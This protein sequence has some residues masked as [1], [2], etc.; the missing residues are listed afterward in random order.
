MSGYTPDGEPYVRT[1]DES[2]DG[3]YLEHN[4]IS[5]NPKT[6]ATERIHW[7]LDLTTP[8]AKPEIITDEE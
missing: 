1:I 5:F 8:G 2:N 7:K 6:N 3:H 4:E